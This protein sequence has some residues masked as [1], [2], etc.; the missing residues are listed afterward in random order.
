VS[1][2]SANGASLLDPFG[3]WKTMRDTQLEAWSKL[4]IDLVNSDE[5]SKAT[6]QALEQF[7]TSSQPFRSALERA[8]T[9]SL[10]MMNMPSRAEVVTLAERLVNVEMRLDD[11]DA[12]LSDIHKSLRST[13]KA[14]FTRV[15][16]QAGGSQPAAVIP[17]APDTKPLEARLDT[18]DTRL[19][20]LLKTLE[21]AQ[22]Q[23]QTTVPGAKQGA[24]T[25]ARRRRAETPA[26]TKA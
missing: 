10:A 13:I 9:Q 23:P 2:T 3:V 19:E 4:M 11:L 1:E 25:P 22:T 12:K 6:G 17:P 26:K 15:P 7:L 5:Y 21:K 14:A 8:M 16:A 20:A 24:A 18:L